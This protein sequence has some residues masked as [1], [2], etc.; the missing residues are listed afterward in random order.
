M[1]KGKEEETYPNQAPMA[2][3]IGFIFG[4]GVDAAAVD[5]VIRYGTS[6]G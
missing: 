5:I 3:S 2:D 1:R 6:V 4:G